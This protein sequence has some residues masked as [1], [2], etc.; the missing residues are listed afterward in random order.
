MSAILAG[1]LRDNMALVLASG[2]AGVGQAKAIVALGEQLTATA[3][4][5][6]AT[7]PCDYIRQHQGQGE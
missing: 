2:T 6:A 7:Q 1:Q 4:A 3:T 5:A